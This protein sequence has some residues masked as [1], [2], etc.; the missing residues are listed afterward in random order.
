MKKIL[1][2]TS[3][4][5]N[6][7]KAVLDLLADAGMQVILN[8]YKRKLTESELIDLL[9]K[10]QPFGLLAGTEPITGKVLESSGGSVKVI[11]RVGVGW[12]NV[13]HETA[14]KLGIR[15]FRTQGVLNQAVAELTLG[16]I[17]S[18]LRHIC[19]QDRQIRQGKWEKRMGG[20]L[21]GRTVGIIG[22]GGIG[23]R[24]GELVK[25]FGAVVLYNDIKPVEITWGSACSK[26][27]IINQ[28]D[29][30]VLN[31]SGSQC[32]LGK[33]EIR[34]CRPGA[35][36]VNTARGGLVD[37]QAL[38]DALK[39]GRVGFACLDVFEEEPYS[40]PLTEL[41]NVIMTCHVGSYALEARIRM[42]LNAAENMIY[43]LEIN[44]RQGGV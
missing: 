42:E 4:F 25:A 5:A 10:E 43:G 27:D 24:V 17:L 12:D 6:Q 41:E 33:A 20:L 28:S 36:I 16:H 11:S 30:I 32:I 13:D 18:A 3:S 19:I 29:I 21:E 2:T 35:I 14:R 31:A 39:A 15:V 1:A 7:N 40:G 44:R 26:F 8:P 9:K 23:Q 37:E 38:Y 34:S 22:F